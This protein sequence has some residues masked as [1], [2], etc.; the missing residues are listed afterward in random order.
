MFR[1]QDF[2]RLSGV[3]AKALRHYDRLG[4]LRPAAV[5]P[6]T[7]YRSY[8]AQQL[9]R[10]QRILAMRDLGFTLE[11]IATLL[12]E[13][14]GPAGMRRRLLRQ[15]AETEQ[16]LTSESRRLTALEARL[17]ELDRPG[18]RALDVVIRALPAQAVVTRRRRVSSLDDGARE[19]FEAVEADAAAWGIRAAGAPLLLYHD[20]DYREREAD[21]E[22]AV[23]V[24]SPPDSALTRS[25]RGSGAAV[26][27]LPAVSSAACLVYAGP[28][29]QLR[30]RLRGV[31][32]WLAIQ[33]LRMIA[34][35]REAYL[36][37][38]ANAAFE[39][40]LPPAYLAEEAKELVTEI[41]VPIVAP[42]AMDAR[43]ARWRG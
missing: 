35:W 16:R 11:E 10:L 14:L 42:A 7:R 21:I 34:P 24:T 38:H 9:V 39:L 4:L 29:E 3:S 40:R 28:Y 19:L 20:A 2:S 13:K 33:G 26:R 17:R 37:F 1:I 8:T 5:D 36:Q 22:A 43:D 27:V 15:R 23:P 41:Q 6:R 18:T 31:R 25:R 32:D 30:K 12:D